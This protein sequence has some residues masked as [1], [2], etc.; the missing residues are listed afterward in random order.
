MPVDALPHPPGRLP[1]VGDV[2]SVGRHRQA[3]HELKLAQRGL[4]P[5]FGRKLLGT[6]LIILAGGRLAAQCNDEAADGNQ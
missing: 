1:I 2:A 4:G 3:Q 6:Q 5:I